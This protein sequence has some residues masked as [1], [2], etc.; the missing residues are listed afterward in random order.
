MTAKVYLLCGVPGSGKSWVIAQL[1]DKFHYVSHDAIPTRDKLVRHCYAAACGPRPVVVDCPF[2]ERI[3]RE[4]L[5]AYGMQ[6]VPVFIVEAPS[7]IASRYAQREGKPA[8]KATLTRA[9]T[10]IDRANEWGAKYGTAIEI[11]RHLMAV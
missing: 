4:E 11:F 2:A 6:V 3:L 5:E 10:I 7:V 9:L 8:T 1:G